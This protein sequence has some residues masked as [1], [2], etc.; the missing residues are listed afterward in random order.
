MPTTRRGLA[1]AGVLLSTFLAAAE[2][3][4]VAT[5]MPSVVADLG[6][7]E[8]YG[9]VSAIYMLAMTVT[10]PIHGKL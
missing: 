9:W 1:I 4:I 3:T 7:L 10:I 2:S 5:A 6:G 8:L